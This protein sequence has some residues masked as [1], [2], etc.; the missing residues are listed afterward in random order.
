MFLWLRDTSYLISMVSVPFTMRCHLIRL[1]S[2]PF[3]YLPFG[4]VWFCKIA[5]CNAWRWSRMANLRRVGKTS[6]YILCRLWTK[7]HKFSYDVY[8][9]PLVYFSTSLSSCLW[10][11]HASFIIYSPLSLEVVEKPNRCIVFG[12]NFF[13]GS[14]PIFLRRILSAIHCPPFGKVWLSSVCWSLAREQNAKFTEGG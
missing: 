13:G 8:R 11:F 9:R 7:V 4:K 5:A 6:G 10:V 2:A 14:T 12:P 3:T 1:A